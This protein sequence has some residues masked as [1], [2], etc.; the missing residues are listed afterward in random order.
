[1]RMVH[2]GSKSPTAVCVESYGVDTASFAVTQVLGLLSLCSVKELER[3]VEGSAG[4]WASKATLCTKRIG[5]RRVQ[6]FDR[7]PL[8]WKACQTVKDSL[9][10]VARWLAVNEQGRQCCCQRPA[11]D[12]G[13]PVCR[14]L[15]ILHC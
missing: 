6:L 14:S 10:Y 1:M 12:A 8:V 11:N 9:D 2:H 13:A 4:C 7:A 5:H 15:D 3:G